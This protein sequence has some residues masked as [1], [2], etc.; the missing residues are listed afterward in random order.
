MGSYSWNTTEAKQPSEGMLSSGQSR[1][2]EKWLISAVPLISEVT[3]SAFSK[4]QFPQ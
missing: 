4:S 2:A 3:L 1:D